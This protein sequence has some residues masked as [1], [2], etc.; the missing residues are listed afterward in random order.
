MIHTF[1]KHVLLNITTGRLYTDIGEVYDF[2]NTVIEPGFFTQ[3]LPR[4]S[5]AIEP[6][7]KEKLPADMFGDFYNPEIENVDVSFEF[8]DED[9]KRFLSGYLAQPNPLDGKQVIGI[10]HG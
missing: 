6:I 2:F 3:M 1:K 9:K 10:N 7:L 8:T 4:A 5:R